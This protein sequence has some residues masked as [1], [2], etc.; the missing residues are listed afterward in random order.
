M[1]SPVFQLGAAKRGA[2]VRAL[3]VHTT[4]NTQALPFVA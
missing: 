2:K 3:C 1:R 4:H